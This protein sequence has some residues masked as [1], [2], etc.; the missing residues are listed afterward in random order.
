MRLSAL[1]ALR[2]DWE[3][4]GTGAEQLEKEQLHITVVRTESETGGQE[5]VPKKMLW[6]AGEKVFNM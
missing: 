3:H 2:R 6:T 4:I 5:Q 1:A